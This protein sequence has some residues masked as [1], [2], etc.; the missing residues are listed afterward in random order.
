MVAADQNNYVVK[1]TGM[2]LSI[3]YWMKKRK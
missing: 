1:L 2:T 3:D